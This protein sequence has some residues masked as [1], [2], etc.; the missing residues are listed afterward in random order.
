MACNLKIIPLAEE[1]LYPN[2]FLGVIAGSK[3]ELEISTVDGP[4]EQGDV[5]PL[6]IS[7]F[8]QGMGDSN[9]DVIISIESSSKYKF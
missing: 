3:Y 1:N 7:V 8:N 4:F 9:G 6:N 5:Y 2:Q